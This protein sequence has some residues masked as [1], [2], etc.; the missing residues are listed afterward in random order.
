MRV[1]ECNRP[2]SQPHAGHAGVTVTIPPRIKT[3]GLYQEKLR[4]AVF[5]AVPGDV[6]QLVAGFQGCFSPS[7]GCLS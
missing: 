5:L 6:R 2:L 3:K 4:Q 1:Q 7:S